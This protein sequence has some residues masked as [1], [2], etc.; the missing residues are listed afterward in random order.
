MAFALPELPD[1][2]LDVVATGSVFFT[3]T[4]QPILASAA[5]FAA[6]LV[7]HNSRLSLLMPIVFSLA[8]CERQPSAATDSDSGLNVT[9]SCYDDSCR[10]L[11]A[12]DGKAAPYT[13]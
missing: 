12:G 8:V 6:G 4:E 5:W 2:W 10:L 13:K 1:A 7:G 9:D 3:Q 11:R